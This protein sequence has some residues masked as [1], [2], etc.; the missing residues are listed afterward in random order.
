MTLEETEPRLT[1]EELFAIMDE[2]PD[3]Y[4]ALDLE[5]INEIGR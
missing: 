3:F 5:D 2:A 4:R 1:V